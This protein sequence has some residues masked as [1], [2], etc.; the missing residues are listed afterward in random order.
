[1][2]AEPQ[3]PTARKRR[4][5]HAYD[6][7]GWDAIASALD[8]SVSTAQKYAKRDRNPVPVKRIPGLGVR[9]SSEALAAWVE[10]NA[11]AA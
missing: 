10:T 7:D 3:K 2:T 4:M 5:V 6:I 11:R 1:M 8:V 9:A